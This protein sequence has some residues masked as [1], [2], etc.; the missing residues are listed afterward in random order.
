LIRVGWR[1]EDPGVT[2][3]GQALV[4]ASLLAGAL[5]AWVV[6]VQRMRGMDAG[7]GTDLGALGWYV[8]VW[9]T[10]TAAMMLPSAAPAVRMFAGLRGARSACVFVAGYLVAW[11]AYGLVAFGVYRAVR[12]AEP[13]F[14]AWDRRGPWVAGAA[15]VVAGL[16]QV[17]PLKS[18]CLRHCRS[19]VGLLLRGRS[20]L[21]LG[22][23]HGGYCI[24]CCFGLMLTL[25]VLGVMSVTW[26]VAVALAIVL[27][28]VVPGGERVAPIL[29]AVLVGLGIWVAVSP[30]SV[31]ALTQPGG[32]SMRMEP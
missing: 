1:S 5:A 17:T 20:A 29:A 31:P 32:P 24:G 15:L 3:R 27:E 21:S 13:S 11:T 23:V 30:T 16:Y 2:V 18:A 6:T 4:V 28:K 9:L 25:F 10:M 12:A 7:P 19:P 22:I 14:L 26:M 8:G